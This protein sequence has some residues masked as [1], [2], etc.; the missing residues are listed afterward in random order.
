MVMGFSVLLSVYCKEKP[1][2]LKESLASI[3]HQTLLPDEVVLIQ[4]GP[5]TVDLQTI[6]KDYKDKHSQLVTYSFSE[7]VQLGR[8]LAKGVELCSYDLIARMDT[9]DVAVPQRFEQQYEYMQAH[10]EVVACGG[11]MEEFND[12]GTYAKVKQMPER[13][14]E[15]RKY[16][17]YRNP[18]NHMT[19]MMRR[20][21]VLQVGNYRHFPYLEDYDLWSR[22]L[23]TSG[24]FY[25]MPVVLVKMRNNDSL[26]ERRGGFEYFRQYIALRKQQR[27]MGLINGGEYVVAYFLTMV[28]TLQPT[29]LRKRIY[30][31]I[32]RKNR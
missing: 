32:L 5:L 30:Q 21:Q 7:N 2:Y 4:D 18:L 10:P 9:D 16:A 17:K 23:A 22:M 26:Y 6:I 31:R 13:N 29:F 19:V 14:E 24:E 1:E 3:F 11:W 15:I 8:A 20:S 25:N 27:S 12:E 28:M